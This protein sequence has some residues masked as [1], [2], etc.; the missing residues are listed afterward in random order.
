MRRNDVEAAATKECCL[1]G[2][3]IV[4]T[5]LRVPWSRI[6]AFADE[7]VRVDDVGLFGVNDGGEVIVEFERFAGDGQK[8]AQDRNE[9]AKARSHARS[10]VATAT[11]DN[12]TSRRGA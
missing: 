8:Q 5:K 2:R 7:P 12:R 10:G 3:K 1:D 6:R 4:D 9:G 11:S